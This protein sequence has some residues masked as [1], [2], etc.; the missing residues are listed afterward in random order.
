MRKSKPT[1]VKENGSGVDYE[2][3]Y[4]NSYIRFWKIYPTPPFPKQLN[5][6]NRK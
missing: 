6:L 4:H 3:K 1:Q 5:S 2:L